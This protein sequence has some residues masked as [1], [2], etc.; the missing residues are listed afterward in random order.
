MRVAG[1][2]PLAS[3]EAFK[4]HFQFAEGGYLY[5]IGPG[6]GSR[7]TAFLTLY[8]P[9]ISGLDSN[10]VTK[11][12]DFSFPNGLERWMELDKK[13]GTETYTIIFAP[14]PLTNLLF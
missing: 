14:S 6:E 5:I 2:V 1:A 10:L 11:E 9:E 12:Q 4:F 13:P 8:P 7:P 3:G